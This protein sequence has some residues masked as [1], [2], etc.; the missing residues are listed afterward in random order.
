MRSKSTVQGSSR[1]ERELI[2]R[3]EQASPGQFSGLG[4]SG[5]RSLTHTAAR[6]PA[7]AAPSALRPCTASQA[8]CWQVQEPPCLL[9]PPASATAAQR[10]WLM[11]DTEAQKN[12]HF[13]QSSQTWGQ[14]Q[15]WP[16]IPY[17]EPLCPLDMT[18][19][20]SPTGTFP[21]SPATPCC[22][23]PAGTYQEG[24]GAGLSG[25]P[26]CGLAPSTPPGTETVE[27]PEHVLHTCYLA[28]SISLEGGGLSHCGLLMPAMSLDYE[29][30]PPSV[31]TLICSSQAGRCSSQ[32]K[33][34]ERVALFS[35]WA[36]EN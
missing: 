11:Q 10:L 23:R 15:D 7:D 18:L 21:G 27:A 31:S 19:L 12:G 34:G 32:R 25:Q 14:K 16:H 26:C 24:M 20:K 17:S 28:T 8:D 35:P 1:L 9:S 29:K 30:R 3:A 4:I 6:V 33:R 36:Q 5:D 2:G 13:S 22:G